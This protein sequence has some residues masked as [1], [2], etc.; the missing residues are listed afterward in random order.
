MTR[1]RRRESTKR[2]KVLKSMGWRNVRLYSF[3]VVE[4]RV[5]S[6]GRMAFLRKPL[7][8]KELSLEEWEREV[9]F[10]Q[11]PS[12]EFPKPMS[13]EELELSLQGP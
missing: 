10:P 8:P 7:E 4:G 1:R 12:E 11:R 6:E 5:V 3:K 9:Y 2:L 13:L